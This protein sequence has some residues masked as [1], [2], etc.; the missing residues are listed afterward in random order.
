MERNSKWHLC[1]PKLQPCARSYLRQFRLQQVWRDVGTDV[2]L[3][4]HHIAHSRERK[5]K[6][7]AHDILTVP[8]ELWYKLHATQPRY[9]PGPYK[10]SNRFG[11][12]RTKGYRIGWYPACAPSTEAKF[13]GK[14]STQLADHWYFAAIV[15]KSAYC[16]RYPSVLQDWCL[17]LCSSAKWQS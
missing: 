5:N 10:G 1:Y 13:L 15:V 7:T 17:R 16:R 14:L 11:D 4:W 9:R 12:F 6:L 3:E 8:S 2:H